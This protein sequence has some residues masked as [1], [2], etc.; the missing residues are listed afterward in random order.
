MFSVAWNITNTCTFLHYRSDYLYSVRSQSIVIDFCVGILNYIEVS[1][2][3]AFALFSQCVC[4]HV[5]GLLCSYCAPWS[6]W[7]S[8]LLGM[9]MYFSWS[10][11]ILTRHERISTLQVSHMVWWGWRWREQQQQNEGKE[12]TEQKK[13]RIHIEKWR[14]NQMFSHGPVVHSHTPT[15]LFG[16]HFG[17]NWK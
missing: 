17:V 12:E 3:C 6:H 7:N 1:A 5:G 9:Y 16:C 10:F 2:L 15:L 4:V 8:N 14:E 13:W 11:A